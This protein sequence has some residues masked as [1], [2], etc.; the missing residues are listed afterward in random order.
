MERQK[1]GGT[2]ELIWRDS[3]RG[4]PETGGGREKSLAG[5]RTSS[6]KGD[7]QG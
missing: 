3:D 2:G 4:Q 6:C 7:G 5:S 1:L